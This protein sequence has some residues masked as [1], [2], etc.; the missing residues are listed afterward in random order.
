MT[1]FIHDQFAKD[2]LEELLTPYGEV[3]AARRVAGEVREIDVY[4]IP[5]QPSNISE[6]LGLLGQFATTPALFEPFRN[7]AAATEICDCLLKLLEVRGDLQRQANRNNT[8]IQESDLPKLWILTPTASASLLSGFGANPKADFLPGVYFMADYLRTAIVAIH[9]LPIIPETLWLRII[10]RGNVQKQAIDEL[11]ALSPNN[12]FR[13]AALELLYNLQQNLQ[14]TQNPDEEDR[15]LVMR[16][17]PLYQQDR[18]QAIQEGE[19]LVVENLLRVRFGELDNQLQAI[20][21]PLLA[22]SPEEFTP[23]LLQL[24]REELIAR[25]I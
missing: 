6:T 10:G 8:R 3:Q 23:L 12:P 4:F 2:Y 22:L 9:Q 19:R 7:P 15:E 25:F 11:E 20:I 16:L 1:R 17:A 18:E 21:E 13:K 5:T 24:S 14:F